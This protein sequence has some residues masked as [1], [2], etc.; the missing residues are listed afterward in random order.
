LHLHH[1]ALQRPFTGNQLLSS[2]TQ[3]APCS[4][5]NSATPKG[6]GLETHPVSSHA[7]MSSPTYEQFCQPKSILTFTV[8]PLWVPH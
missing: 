3:R 1:E 5:I 4:N 2:H 6:I 7:H 8:Y